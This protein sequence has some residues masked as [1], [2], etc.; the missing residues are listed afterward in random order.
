MTRILVFT[1]V[2]NLYLNTLAAIHQI[3][4]EG[5][6]AWLQWRDNP[7]TD[8]RANVTGAYNAA[9]AVCLAGAYDALLTIEN[10]IIPPHD[11]LARLIFADADI[12]YGL[13]CYRQPGHLWNAYFDGQSLCLNLERARIA[14]GR[15]VHVQG[16]GL[17]CA[18]IRRHVLADIEFRF[19]PDQVLHCDSYF[20]DAAHLAG[21]SQ[22]CDLGLHCGH[23]LNEY[24]VVY[25]ALQ[26]DET[27]DGAGR[28]RT[29]RYEFGN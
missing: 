28:W 3:E 16:Y 9:R 20:C 13:Y 24:R 21:F 15:H 12:A 18:L 27:P 14:W 22:V 29:Y 4:H 5:P 7:H 25:P 26:Q 2:K 19:E 11:T 23:I 10:D 8:P 17:G 1:A 6:L